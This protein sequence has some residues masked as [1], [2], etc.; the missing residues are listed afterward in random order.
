MFVKYEIIIWDLSIGINLITFI[1]ISVIPLSGAHCITNLIIRSNE[2]VFF[3]YVQ[4]FVS[5][6]IKILNKTLNKML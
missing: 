3:S 6:E 5:V 2:G 1:M 4:H